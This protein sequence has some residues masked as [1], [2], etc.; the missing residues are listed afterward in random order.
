MLPAA[1]VRSRPHTASV[2]PNRFRSP[3]A[4]TA[5]G[6]LFSYM[7]VKANLSLT[8]LSRIRVVHGRGSAQ[9]TQAAAGGAA[10]HRGDPGRR[11]PDPRRPAGRVGGRDRAGRRG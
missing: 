6:Y 2:A 9:E 4:S 7:V 3:S 1:T 5:T 8:R 10:V 11:D